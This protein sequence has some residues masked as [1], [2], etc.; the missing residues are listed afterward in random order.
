MDHIPLKY[1]LWFHHVPWDHQLASGRTLLDELEYRYNRGVLYV[2]D[3]KT[4]WI[5]LKGRVDAQMYASVLE[6]L[7]K[8]QQ[9]A[10]SWET[11]CM[12]YFRGVAESR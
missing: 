9:W 7:N 3:M 1:L 12:D 6:Q 2:D 4:E 10:R 11:T 8:E 5:G